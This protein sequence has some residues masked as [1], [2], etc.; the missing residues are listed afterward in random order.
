MIMEAKAIVLKCMFVV[1]V[2]WSAIGVAISQTYAGES[3][4]PDAPQVQS[5]SP[6]GS[7]VPVAT[8]QVGVIQSANA[9]ER[10]AIEGAQSSH[11]NRS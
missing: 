9:D 5:I 6:I 3:V 8:K 7:Q 2:V 1:L 4:L 10:R 11:A